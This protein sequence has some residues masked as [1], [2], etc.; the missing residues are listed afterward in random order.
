MRNVFWFLFAI[1][2]VAPLLLAESVSNDAG[3]SL[4]VDAAH[5]DYQIQVKDPAWVV[6]GTIGSALTDLSASDGEDKLG[7]YHE[8]HFS[9]VEEGKRSGSIRLYVSRPLV[10]F[11]ETFVDGVD[12]SP[13]PFPVLSKLPENL[14]EFRYGETDHLRP[15]SFHLATAATEQY[16]GPFTLFDA[17]ANT[18]IL[19]PASDFMIAMMSGDQK[20]GLKS[21]LNRTLKSVPAGYSYQ[22]LLAIDKGI[23]HTFDVWGHAL[24]ELHGKKRPANDAD[25]GLK[26]LG[27]WTDNGAGYYYNYDMDKGYAGTLL[28]LKAH[29]D[30]KGVPIHYMQLDSWWYPKTFTSFEAKSNGKA[31]AKDPKLPAGTW[32]RYGGL[33][34]YTA[35]TDLFP[36]GL[37]DFQK[38]LGLPLITHS[39]WV[40]PESPYQTAYKISGVAAVDPK[41]WDKIIGDISSWGVVT[42]EQD[43]SNWIYLK[44]PELNSTTWAG[45]AFMDGMAN[46]CAAHGVTI[47]LCMVLPRYVL[48]AGAN[49]P[50]FTTV[51]VSGDRLDRNKWRQ[52]LYGSQLASAL[53]VWPWTDVFKS[54]ETPNMLISTL[55]ASMVGLSDKIGDEDLTNI[56]RAVRKDGVIVKPD[57]PMTPSDATYIA[58]GQGEHPALF[59]STHTSHDEAGIAGM[60]SYVFAF[61]EKPPADGKPGKSWKIE[62]Q[63]LGIHSPAFAYDF[64]NN[65]GQLID[66]GQSL[67]GHFDAQGWNYWVL[68]PVG[69]SGMAFIGDTGMFVTRGKKR[70]ASIHDEPGRLETSVLL[71]TGEHGVTLG[72][73]ALSKPVVDVKNGSCKSVTYDAATKLAHVEIVADPAAVSTVVS[74][75]PMTE[76]SVTLRLP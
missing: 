8:I 29:L 5:G 23:N 69:P 15:E 76:V 18:L 52:F 2:M 75:D 72:V 31:R 6:G 51:R 38:T 13:M 54:N 3:W 16:G 48:Q 73:Y 60:A 28:A 55:S 39:R 64:F 41:W 56:F 37:G 22:T 44:S 68:A 53:G 65:T 40:D 71:A 58:E 24:T 27:Y 20:G 36:K 4:N 49:Y 66:A 74:G 1:L 70:I 9:W 30:E 43:W 25:T 34:E 21:G 47:Q 26:Y 61:Q 57:V 67:S 50:S 46:A 35:S 32:N 63:S 17:Q 11:A 7:R 59:C 10:L 42:Y 62:P 14:L 12:H 33:L 45:E 19:S